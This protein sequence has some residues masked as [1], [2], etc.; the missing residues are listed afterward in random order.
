MHGHPERLQESPGLVEI[1]QARVVAC[2]SACGDLSAS[3]LDYL[4]TSEELKNVP[5]TEWEIIKCLS[6]VF[7]IAKP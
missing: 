3:H 4:G 6:F 5:L 7:Q 1:K 2:A